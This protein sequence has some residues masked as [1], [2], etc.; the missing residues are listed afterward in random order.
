MTYKNPNKFIQFELWKDC[1]IG[2]KFCCNKGQPK[3]DKK[4]SIQYVMDILNSDEIN[5]YNEIGFIGGEFFNGELDSV[6]ED[7][8]NIFEKVST[9]NF[10]RIYIT[11][12]LMYDLDKSLL[13][14]LHYLEDLKIINKVMICSSFDT[15]YRFKSYMEVERWKFNMKRL[16]EIFPSI[17]LHTEIILTEAF[18]H[19]VL[20]DEFNIDN[21]R[22]E[23][24]TGLDFIEP[25]SGLF[26]YNK[27]S[28]SKDLP[29]FFPHK[30]SFIKFLKKVSVDNNWIDL[31]TFLSMELRSNKLYYIANGQR[32]VANDRRNGDGTCQ[33][34]EFKNKYE[35]GFIDSD[36]SMRE[37][38]KQFSLLYGN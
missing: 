2:C 17:T 35:L 8:Y 21:F 12:S 36:D 24:Q 26:Y 15:M 5:E 3:T 28:A 23:F 30:S 33:I 7:F 27:E 14:F 37:I 11:A 16:K 13:P 29:N 10:D 6:K 25:S 34:P 18:I 22:N 19:S 9:L 31:N 38:S 20:S 1:S 32:L 4:E